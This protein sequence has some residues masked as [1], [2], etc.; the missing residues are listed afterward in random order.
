MIQIK[1]QLCDYKHL[2]QFPDAMPA[3]KMSPDQ[4]LRAIG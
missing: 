1:N 4:I 3:V 2:R